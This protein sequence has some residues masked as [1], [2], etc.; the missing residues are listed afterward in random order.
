MSSFLTSKNSLDFPDRSEQVRGHWSPV[1]IEP[2]IGSGERICIGIAVVSESSHLTV[3]VTAL[4][5]LECVYGKEVDSLLYAS[6]LAIETLQASL[7][8]N[9]ALEAWAPPFEGIYLGR[10]REGAGSS[11][12]DIARAGLT[13]CASLVEKIGESD[14]ETV[15]SGEGL[16]SA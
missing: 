6:K 12:E 8:G 3:P 1:Y 2:M 4:S 16:S 7:K 5:R 9:G 15:R 11:L 10:I 14:E 13:L